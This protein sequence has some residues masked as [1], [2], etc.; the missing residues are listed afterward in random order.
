MYRA[1][2]TAVG[3]VKVSWCAGAAI[4]NQSIIVRCNAANS[5]HNA[6]NSI[7]EGAHNTRIYL[8]MLGCRPG[9]GIT[10]ILLKQEILL[11]YLFLLLNFKGNVEIIDTNA[12]CTNTKIHTT[13]FKD[14]IYKKTL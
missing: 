6:A 13:Y 5:I 2:K 11:F 12:L 9:D 1:A 7:H 14:E 10:K 3:A 8:V 4:I